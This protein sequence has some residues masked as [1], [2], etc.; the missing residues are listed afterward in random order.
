M[1]LRQ[2]GR[3]SYAP[4]SLL[5]FSNYVSRRE[6]EDC[7]KSRVRKI[8]LTPTSCKQT[9]N[10]TVD[11][12]K[13]SGIKIEVLRARGR[14]RKLSEQ[15]VRRVLA[16]RQR[17]LSY[18][19]IEGI[20]GVPKS[21]AHDYWKRQL[22]APL[23]EEEVQRAEFKEARRL[24]QHLMKAGLGEEITELAKRGYASTSA[25]EIAYILEEIEDMING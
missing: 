4:A 7:V 11:F 19:R 15:Q 10:A 1:K 21:T 22:G 20:T 13:N 2:Q 5:H 14:P 8:T 25:E 3:K 12:L 17:N 9:P 24:F 23:G 16:M 18:Y 6:A